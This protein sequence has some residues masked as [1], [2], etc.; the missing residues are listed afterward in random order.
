MRFNRRIL[1]LLISI[2]LGSSLLAQTANVRYFYD[3]SGQLTKV[4]DPAGNVA[5]YSYDAA[6]NLLQIAR[7]SIAANALAILN[8]SPR[9]GGVG[10]TV[11]LQGQGFS[12]TAAQNVVTFNGT[13][14]TVVSATANALVVTVPAGATTGPVSVTVNNQIATADISFTVTQAPVVLAVNPRFIVESPTTN[15]VTNFSVSGSSLNGATFSFLPVLSPPAITV[16][17]AAVDPSGTSATLSITVGANVSG[18]FTLVASSGNGG[19]SSPASTA[20]NTVH[21]LDPNRD[22]DNDGLTN[23]VEIALGTDPL[24]HST[25]N[26]GIDDGWK[27][28]YGFNPLDPSVAGQDADGDGL[29]N[30]Q[31]F[32]QGTSPRNPDV[33]PPAVSQVFP[34]SSVTTY[35][36][37]GR[38][39]VRFT[40][41]LLTGVPLSSAQSAISAAAPTLPVS[42][43]TAAA[44]T[45]QNYLQHTCCANSVVAGVVSLLQ[46][47]SAVNGTFQISNDGLSV[48]FTPAQQLAANTAY[49]EQ[50]NHA[51]DLAGNTMTQQFQGGFTTGQATD[52]TTPVAM[53]SSPADGA[54][55]VPTNAAITVQFSKVMDPATLTPSNFT[56]VDSVT[57]Q[58]V[59]GNIQVDASGL[60]AAFMPDPPLAVGRVFF[61]ELNSNIK[62]AFGNSLNS[63]SFRFT[64]GFA[65]DADAPHLLATSPAD[66]AANVPTNALIVLRF[67]ETLNLVTATSAIQVFGGGQAVPGSIALSDANRL[68]T[69]T[70]ATPLSANTSYT[71][72]IGSGIADLAD[73]LIDNPSSFTFQTGNAADRTPPQVLSF[74]PADGTQN[75]PVNAVVE[76]QF[77]KPM[78]PLTITPATFLVMPAGGSPIAG[79][80]TVSPDARSAKFTPA[81]PL[82]FSTMYAAVLTTD[83]NDLVGQNA[84]F[85]GFFNVVFRFTTGPQSQGAGPQVLA[86]SP[87]NSSSGNP[88]NAR[89]VVALNEPVEPAS[90]TSSAIAVSAGGVAVSGSVAISADRTK[91]TFT[92]SPLAA[93]TTYNVTVAGFTDVAGNPVTPF[94]SSFTTATAADNT[95]LQV[96]SV[97]PPNGSTGIPIATN[98]V[99]T[100]N[101]AVDATTVS[102]SSLPVQASGANVAGNYTVNGAVVSFAPLNPLPGN[103]QI[104]VIAENPLQDA[105]GNGVNFFS[106]SFTTA[107][108][109]STTLP[110][111]VSVAPT[112]GATNI[113]LNATVVLTFSESLN[114][115][116]VNSNTFGLL[117]NSGVPLGVN[118]SISADNRTVM[119]NANALPASSA[120]TVAV[121]AGVQDLSG[122]AL[123][124]FRSQFNT[125][126]N[127]DGS[128]ATVTSQR[129]GNGASGVGLNSNIVLFMN[130]PLNA[131]TVSSAL[132]V[133]QNGVLVPGTVNV[134]GNGQ[135]IQFFPASPWQNNA[136]V[137]VF[138]DSTAVDTD[139]SPVSS[140]QG[141]FRTAA[142]TSSIAPSPVSSTPSGFFPTN[143]LQNTTVE[144]LYNEPLD[145]NSVNLNTVL[146]QNFT[147]GRVLVAG[148]VSL[149][150][151]GTL[152]RFI[153]NV[154]LPA[155]S[156]YELLVT[157]A[158][159]GLNGL[160]QGSDRIVVFFTTGNAIDTAPPVVTLVSPPDGLS[161]VPV[162]AEIRVRFN[163]TIN[164]LTV[165]A[166]TIQVSGGGQT[167]VASSLSFSNNNQD[168]VLTPQEAFPDNTLLT[169]AI[170]GVQDLA[171]NNVVSKTTQFTTGAG[172]TTA[173]AV[174][175]TETPVN[176]D[177]TVP[178]NT[179]ITAHANVP[180]DPGTVNSNSFQLIDRATNQVVSGSYS[181]SADG[182]TLSFVPNAALAVNRNYVVFAGPGMSDLA[183]NPATCGDNFFCI[184]FGS[185][186]FTTSTTADTVPPTVVG[187]SPPDQVTGVPIN[188]QVMVQFSEPVN[189]LTL[190]P[191]T[192]SSASG[193]VTAVPTLSNGQTTL[194]L[195]PA[196]PLAANT[197]YSVSVAGVQDLSGN[198][199]TA[200]VTTSFTT[201]TG[202]DLVRPQLSTL[203]P[204]D[205][206]TG[207]ATN[208]VVEAQ[209][210]KRM[211]ALTFTNANFQVIPSG[212]NPIAGTIT[213]AADGQSATFTP[214][215]PLSPTTTYRVR[216]A[217]GI[218][219]LT[220]QNFGFLGIFDFNSSFT[221]GAQ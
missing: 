86:V 220:G 65:P 57:N 213:V 51:R 70:P 25:V 138:L 195:T 53:R 24:N 173:Q 205:G 185:I 183:G 103:A 66:A 92:P 45:L 184:A 139:G 101:K 116:T 62:D 189:P 78:D 121:T 106:S 37:N 69:F 204:A 208:A 128:H 211:D 43:A 117:S 87:G 135:T 154:P 94:N 80:V 28:F 55:N 104:Q 179:L 142:D 169:V 33:V 164:P 30:L 93:A 167:A 76:V 159:T 88:L 109:R 215:V 73:R 144:I 15:T 212:G 182:Q 77:S 46:G 199:M 174:V 131:S 48:T 14:A 216:L 1:G 129:P 38:V 52:T 192:V 157:G 34:S 44:L 176:G 32:L 126:A 137:Q 155:N 79:T 165:N 163:K 26:D 67:N 148:T 136:L 178:V 75:L 68:L 60:T 4:V 49:A 20:A 5:T 36:V 145:P 209:F 171:G 40:E 210:S 124:P 190:G 140:Y 197:Q 175:I 194:L 19:T 27:V 9:Q 152:V 84:G 130:E 72:T 177:T 133:S 112:D 100:F 188:T 206:A 143:I 105:A 166:A 54:T 214:S 89:V 96:L 107:A 198:V 132:H 91:L 58:P 97:T 83:I 127:F 108:V 161:G 191:V 111:V 119:L 10:S 23:A 187:V 47:S 160:S 42:E 114:P 74:S 71:V 118:V 219:D 17:S 8:V 64:T 82:S 6:G 56:V 150:S 7:A 125:T 207:V 98:L 141:S 201:G 35:P 115:S 41:P 170:S 13:P 29:T 122:N 158:I 16:T 120:V 181:V 172:P 12:T 22:D 2:G 61:P 39:I 162:N 217:L 193:P 134:Q 221:T 146:L 59:S 202:A 21:I 147:A 151:S 95:A 85:F 102:A 153:P 31:E 186:A 218:T 50:V 90:V 63:A 110:Q 196:I 168:V 81:A 123:L 156:F 200:P 18:A 113:G 180:I 149:D 203:S 99:L 3:D 11:T